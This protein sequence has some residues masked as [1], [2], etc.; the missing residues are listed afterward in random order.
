MKGSKDRGLNEVKV[1]V[2]Y[3]CL[4][5]QKQGKL[6][7]TSAYVQ[8]KATWSAFPS[9]MTKKQINETVVCKTPKT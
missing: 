6:N 4:R 5:Y 7:R 9:N 3:L 8:D 1:G 2:R